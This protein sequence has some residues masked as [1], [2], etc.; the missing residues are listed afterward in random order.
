MICKFVASAVADVEM[1]GL[2]FVLLS[3]TMRNPVLY[4]RLNAKIVKKV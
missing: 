1:R 2:W 4:P 3:V